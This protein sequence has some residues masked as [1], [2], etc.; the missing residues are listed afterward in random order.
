MG[1]RGRIPSAQH[2]AR[3]TVAFKMIILIIKER[4]AEAEEQVMAN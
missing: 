1:G 3:M 4:A 2:D